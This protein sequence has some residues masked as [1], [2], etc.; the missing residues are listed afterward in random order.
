[1]QTID[2]TQ[3]STTEL[4]AALAARQAAATNKAQ[5]NERQSWRTYEDEVQA[6]KD[7]LR[8]KFVG[9]SPYHWGEQLAHAGVPVAAARVV[10]ECVAAIFRRIEALE[11]K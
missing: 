1:M 5:E 8:T 6:N 2:L 10:A 9:Q 7:T 4:E 3:V 11:K